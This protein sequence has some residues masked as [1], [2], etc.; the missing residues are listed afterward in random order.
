MKHIIIVVSIAVYLAAMS[1]Y[2]T[3]GINSPGWDTLFHCSSSSLIILLSYYIVSFFQFKVVN[4]SIYSLI[5]YRFFQSFL[6]LESYFTTSTLEEFYTSMNNY[7]ASGF[8]T[9]IC[10]LGLLTIKFKTTKINKSGGSK[11]TC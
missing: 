5:S 10:V 4:F 7:T 9:F 8:L 2:H 1:F 11:G 6:I 3:V